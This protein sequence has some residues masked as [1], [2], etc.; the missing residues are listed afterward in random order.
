M[1]SPDP[2]AAR[3]GRLRW[4]LIIAT[5]RQAADA[6]AGATGV[7]N[8]IVDQQRVYGDVQPIGPM[9][10]YAAT[11]VDTPVT[12]RITIRWLDWIDTT[13]VIFRVTSRL[14]G[15]NRIE[16]FRIRRV[17]E[18]DGRKRFLRIEAELE[19]YVEDVTDAA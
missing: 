2:G 15:S 14:D 8:S 6:E 1:A 17:M 3:I 12:H 13:H 16:R 7:L 10:F 5:R 4:A 18:E 9:T 19:R 11:Q